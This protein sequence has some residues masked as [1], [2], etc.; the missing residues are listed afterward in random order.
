MFAT[1][2]L[3]AFLFIALC[4][5]AVKLGKWI[6]LEIKQYK[7]QITLMAYVSLVLSS[8]FYESIILVI[9]ILTLTS[10]HKYFDH[11]I[12]VYVFLTILAL[13]LTQN[14]IWIYSLM[15]IATIS[16]FA[17]L[18]TCLNNKH[19]LYFLLITSIFLLV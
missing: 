13:A 15:S 2:L 8:I 10:L 6:E 5:A 7:K 4:F 1:Q 18:R 19:L 3:I 17:V 11:P 12:S 9:I 16:K 14:N